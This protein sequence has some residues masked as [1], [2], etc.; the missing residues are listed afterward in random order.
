[1]P[2]Y[3]RKTF[4]IFFS[5]TL[6]PQF[7]NLQPRQQSALFQSVKESFTNIPMSQVNQNLVKTDLTRSRLQLFKARRSTQKELFCFTDLQKQQLITQNGGAAVFQEQGPGLERLINLCQ[8]LT[9]LSFV[10]S[11][12]ISPFSVL[13]LSLWLS[14]LCPLPPVPRNCYKWLRGKKRG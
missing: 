2:A 6:P 1:M 13:R 8:S 5:L 9:S 3:R 11:R 7:F 10:F 12:L 14:L 4:L